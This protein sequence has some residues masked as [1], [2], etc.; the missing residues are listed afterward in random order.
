MAEENQAALEVQEDKDEI[1]VEQAELADS[2]GVNAEGAVL[3]EIYENVARRAAEQRFPP[4]LPEDF[5]AQG[6]KDEAVALSEFLSKVDCVELQSYIDARKQEYFAGSPD[7]ESI[8]EL[9]NEAR[10][11]HDFF[12]RHCREFY[13]Q[14]SL[15]EGKFAHRLESGHFLPL[16]SIASLSDEEEKH[17]AQETANAVGD[18]HISQIDAELWSRWSKTTALLRFGTLTEMEAFTLFLDADYF[19][20]IATVVKGSA[21]VDFLSLYDVNQG[22]VDEATQRARSQVQEMRLQ[23]MLP[24]LKVNYASSGHEN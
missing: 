2:E 10:W 22:S 5:S 18:A 15:T 7:G 16:L 19:S 11:A 13:I 14:K 12:Y 23:E 6:E 3:A 20:V 1:E 4:V 17:M 9:M 21:K 24:R 8:L